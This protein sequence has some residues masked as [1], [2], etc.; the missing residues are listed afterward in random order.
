MQSS[1]SQAS[2]L[3]ESKCLLRI[4]VFHSVKPYLSN[5]KVNNRAVSQLF[6]TLAKSISIPLIFTMG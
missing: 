6:N 3:A 4:F 2:N 1:K 5:Q